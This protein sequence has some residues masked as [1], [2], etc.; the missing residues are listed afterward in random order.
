MSPNYRSQAVRS[1]NKFGHD[2][3]EDLVGFLENKLEMHEKNLQ[4]K[5]SEYE[6]LLADHSE[7]QDKFNMST[8]KYKRAAYILT[9]FMEELLTGAPGIL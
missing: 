5:H 1:K 9:E 2:G 7:L 8:Q 6:Q 4:L 3:S